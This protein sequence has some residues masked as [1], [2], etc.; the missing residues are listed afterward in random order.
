MGG[1]FE[2]FL[3]VVIPIGLI[4]Y[5][6]VSTGADHGISFPVFHIKFG[7]WTIVSVGA[8]GGTFRSGFA[9]SKKSKC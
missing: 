8:G 3:E 7:G 2:V 4:V 5:G 1:V 9:A 6:I